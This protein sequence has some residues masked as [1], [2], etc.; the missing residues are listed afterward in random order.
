MKKNILVLLAIIIASSTYAQSTLIT[1]GGTNESIS[2]SGLNSG[3]VALGITTTE[4]D[5]IVNPK[6]GQ[7]IY[8]KTSKCYE[9]YNGS[10][11]FNLCESQRINNSLKNGLLAYYPLNGNANDESGN[12]NNGT[13]SNGVNLTID[14]FN[15][16]S[17]AY[18]FNSD[19]NLICT[20]TLIMQPDAFTYSVWIK[21]NNAIT[22]RADGGG[23]HIIGF[24]DNRCNN[25][26]AWDCVLWLEND[27]IVFYNYLDPGIS[28]LNSGTV[29]LIDDKWHHCVVTLDGNGSKIYVDGNLIST[30]SNQNQIQKFNGYFR[31][32][33]LTRSD[34][35]NSMIGSYD[36]IG[37]WNRA[38]TPEEIEYLFMSR[39]YP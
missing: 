33:G 29:S 34:I 18:N 7:L 38:L 35:N 10:Y 16:L 1:S 20:S 4:R 11:W 9:F 2:L 30:K 27:K 24:N 31:I 22:L 26:I 36:D 14:R 3:I 12:G 39:F 8:N 21:T 25:G 28:L 23:S 37:I 13:P 17:K 5:A 15:T 19:A 32:G 6:A